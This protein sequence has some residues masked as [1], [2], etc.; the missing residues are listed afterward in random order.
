[1]EP[2]LKR[3]KF[4]DPLLAAA[5]EMQFSDLNDDCILEIFQ[6][7]SL[8]DLTSIHSTCKRLHNLVFRHILRYF[9][10]IFNTINAKNRQPLAFLEHEEK[11]LNHFNKCFPKVVVNGGC[12]SIAKLFGFIK[13]ECSS[14]LRILDIS[15]DAKL[16]SAAGVIIKDQLQEI[17]TLILRGEFKSSDLLYRVFLR[18]CN[19][20]EHLSIDYRNLKNIC[21]SSNNYSQLKSLTI[22]PYTHKYGTHDDQEYAKNAGNLIRSN[23]QLNKISFFGKFLVQNILR[24]VRDITLKQ[25]IIIEVKSGELPDIINDLE[26]FRV[27]HYEI[28]HLEFDFCGKIHCIPMEE[29]SPE[30][31]ILQNLNKI[32]PIRGLKFVL[33]GDINDHIL[34][35]IAQF[36]HLKNIQSFESYKELPIINLTNKLS[37]KLVHLENLTL[38]FRGFQTMDSETYLKPFVLF[39]EKLKVLTF[40]VNSWTALQYQIDTT[41][42]NELASLRLT[43]PMKINIVG[44][45]PKPRPLKK[46]TYISKNKMLTLTSS[47]GP[48]YH[49]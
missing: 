46:R 38:T 16:Y 49:D 36:N 11:N 13:S 14:T 34:S 18:H 20:L 10:D 43:S 28:E 2:V 26:M 4:E 39:A 29:T 33:G 7:L 35:N 12:S 25:L 8:A 44:E 9:P 40:N 1:M 23:P 19:K 15:S 17:K 27:A 3:K 32:Q 42:L 24:N 48:Y 31:K 41:D 21:W 5:S 37:K 47:V 30:L 6:L 45:A 22:R